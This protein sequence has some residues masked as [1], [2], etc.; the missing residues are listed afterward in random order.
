MLALRRDRV[1]DR[2]VGRTPSVALDAARDCD[3]VIPLEA[4]CVHD[5]VAD[6]VGGESD[7]VDDNPRPPPLESVREPGVPVSVLVDV[8][9]MDTSFD[10]DGVLVMLTEATREPNDG[11]SVKP[12]LRR[13]DLLQDIVFTPDTVSGETEGE[14]DDERRKF[15]SVDVPEKVFSVALRRI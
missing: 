12:R 9:L 15:E 5:T 6:T 1:S 2:V 10:A 4:L 7:T 14:I 11:N 3:A 8:M 13:L